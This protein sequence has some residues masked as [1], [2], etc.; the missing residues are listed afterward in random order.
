MILPNHDLF[1]MVLDKLN[2]CDNIIRFA[3]FS[4]G[5]GLILI[6]T[7]VLLEADRTQ[8]FFICCRFDALFLFLDFECTPIAFLIYLSFI[9]WRYS[10]LTLCRVIVSFAFVLIDFE[11]L[12]ELGFNGVGRI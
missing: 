7:Y 6:A 10:T 1:L 3:D 8:N 2:L 9:N 11:F 12:R 4:E 5:L